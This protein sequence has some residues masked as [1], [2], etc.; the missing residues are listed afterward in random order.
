[1]LSENWFTQQNSKCRLRRE[2]DETMINH[3]NEL[4]KELQKNYKT[5]YDEVGKVIHLQLSQTL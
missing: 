3:I 4:S 5:W 2:K 1:M